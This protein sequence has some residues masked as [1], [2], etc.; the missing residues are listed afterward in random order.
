MTASLD[1]LDAGKA[2]LPLLDGPRVRLR[3]LTLA[4][5]DAL[6]PMFAD[7]ATMRWWSSG[8]HASHGETRAY[9]AENVAGERWPTWAIT[10]APGDT[11]IGWAALAPVREGVREIGYILA[12][13]HWRQG[14]AR[15]ALSLI[16][17]HGFSTL[18]LRRIFADTD[19]DNAAS[20]GL[21]RALGFKEEGLLRAEW[22]THI[23]VRDS[24]ILGLLAHE[25][26]GWSG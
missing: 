11:A 14:L 21:L 12:R 3:A 15:E 6:H 25:W 1:T 2:E 7:E 22:E 20:I 19:P 26:R 10:L 18:G 16:I 17:D 4:D 23:G 9:V 5:A 13:E 24:L 8:P